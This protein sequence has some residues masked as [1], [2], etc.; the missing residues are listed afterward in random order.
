VFENRE[1]RGGSE[2]DGENCI[3]ICTAYQTEG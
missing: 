3:I 1:L 2:D